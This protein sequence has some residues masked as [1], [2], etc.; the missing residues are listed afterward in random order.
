MA[1]Y[2]RLSLAA[3]GGIV[4]I[5]QQANQAENTASL[6]IG[7]GGTGTD[8]LRTI[9]TQ[10]RTRLKPD[11][12]EAI[13]PTYEHIRFLGVD[14]DETQRGDGKK[15]SVAIN[16]GSRMALDETEYF[17]IA[18]PHVDMAF[19]EKLSIQQKRELDWLCYEDIDATK[20]G[21]AGAGGVRQVGR[22]MLMD[23]SNEF[24]ARV[25]EEIRAAREGLLEPTVNV[26]IFA[27]LSGGTG[28]GCFLDVCYMVRSI[29]ERVGGVNIY[30]YF[31]L[32][33]VNASRIPLDNTHVHG[34]L[35]KNGYAS[36]QELDFCMQ[37]QYNGGSFT[38][39]YKGRKR[40]EWK[41][42]P[43]DMCHLVCASNAKGDSIRE[44]YDYAMN[45]TAEYV[46]DFLTDSAD[47]NFKLTSHLANFKSVVGEADSKKTFGTELSYIAIGASCASVPLREI[48]TYLASELFA[49]FARVGGNVPRKV[50][51][52]RLAVRALGSGAESM[53]GVYDALLRRIREG[54]DGDFTWFPH[55]WKFVA[56]Q[57]NKKLVRNYVDQLAAQIGN[58]VANADSMKT[59]ANDNSLLRLVERELRAV[60]RDV[61]RGPI[62]AH[63]LLDAAAEENLFNRIEGLIAQNTVRWEAEKAN[64]ELRSGD[65]EKA[66]NAFEEHLTTVRGRAGLGCKKRFEA[67]EWYVRLLYLH[68]LSLEV[69]RQLDD[70][71]TTLRK[72]LRSRDIGYY[73]RFSRVMQNLIQ[74]FDENHRM[75][76]SENTVMETTGGFSEPLMSIAELK[77]ALDAEV[78]RVDV[79]NM[80]SA[81]MDLLLANEGE[82]V[83][84]DEGHISRLVN[85]FFVEQAFGDFAGRTIT[86][87]LTDKY[88]TT[89]D[90]E[91]A[92]YVYRDWI[93]HLTSKASPLFSFDPSVWDESRTSKIAFVSVPAASGPI[94][95]AGQR[96]QRVNGLWKVK[97]SGL[98]DRIYVMCSAAAFP[99]SAYSK[100]MD[101]EEAFFSEVTAGRHYYEGKPVRGMA[102]NDWRKLP[103]LTPQS[104]IDTSRVPRDLAVAVENARSLFKNALSFG[105]LDEEG[106]IYVPDDSAIGE[107]RDA[108]STAKEFA[109]GFVNK[110]QIPQAETLVRRL[111]VV[112]K[113]RL[114]PSPYKLKSDGVRD[115]DI[116]LSILQDHFVYAPPFHDGI[117]A[118]I[119]VLADI[120]REVAEQVDA[121][122]GRI[123]K[124]DNPDLDNFFDALFSG[125]VAING[126]QVGFE[127]D[128]FGIKSQEV[129]SA[130]DRAAYPFCDVPLYQAFLNYCE[131]PFEDKKD[132]AERASACFSTAYDD[133]AKLAEV[134]KN[135]IS[136]NKIQKWAQF[137]RRQTNRAEIMEFIGEIKER[138]ENHLLEFGVVFG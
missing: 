103:S 23:R 87:F 100:R 17:S 130:H 97:E 63:R 79:P 41:K 94:K 67:Y 16:T 68:M 77:P 47:D 138:L 108:V 6:L 109:E 73:L 99:L 34:F 62:Y 38:Q 86:R 44:P 71:L 43:V 76:Q 123:S 135:E 58:L 11:D 66:K 101:Y 48:N 91:L 122:N 54:A 106:Q 64:A 111:E 8:C 116:K 53:D 136:Y 137:A 35:P 78:K 14:T 75:L 128:E 52:E 57:G 19:K 133:V 15:D 13:L 26:H 31:F 102:F 5:R 24:M 46:M 132:I 29:A 61:E 59:T 40:I 33:D 2:K 81:F 104:L 20:M 90:E 4:S 110:S 88:G 32:P 117:R 121:L 28:A 105:L 25:E 107:A 1:V 72:Q 70:V 118:N 69:Y 125:V 83:S 12:P 21:G 42:A 51:V 113:V 112:G 96:M 84:E 127:R 3:G 124:L 9:K 30:G 56:E 95:A 50:D 93:S 134:L 119:Q 80:L 7:L 37:L 126:Y 27:G 36:L 82:W 10:V 65:V 98:N 22:F 55:D 49:E 60:I 129:L 39:E 120:A 89:T 131:L 114:S 45:V 74:T 85:K 115:S 18:N 92:N